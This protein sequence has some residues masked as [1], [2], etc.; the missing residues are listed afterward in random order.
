[1]HLKP[2]AL[3]TSYRENHYKANKERVA[4]KSMSDANELKLP[5]G[6]V[7]E[8]VEHENIVTS[9]KVYGG[10]NTEFDWVECTVVELGPD[11]DRSL[12][13]LAGENVWLAANVSGPEHTKFGFFDIHY[14]KFDTAIAW[15]NRDGVSQDEEISTNGSV[16][17]PATPIPIQ[18]GEPIGYIGI[19]EYPENTNS[20]IRFEY[21]CHLEVFAPKKPPSW[22]L[23]H[24]SGTTEEGEEAHGFHVIDGANSNGAYDS[25]NEFY[26]EMA[27]LVGWVP[28]AS[29]T[30]ED[31]S[32][33][34]NSGSNQLEKAVICHPT[35]WLSDS[36]SSIYITCQLEIE[37]DQMHTRCARGFRNFE[38]YRRTVFFQN[39][40]ETYNDYVAHEKIRVDD[41]VWV[42]DAVSQG[43]SALQPI[44]DSGNAWHF[45][46][47]GLMPS[48]RGVHIN[49]DEFIALYIPA[50]QQLIEG[51][52]FGPTSTAN[53][54]SI[55]NL[56]NEYY[57]ENPEEWNLHHVAYMLATAQ[58]EAYHFTSGEYFSER[59]EVG[60]REYF[61]KYDPV[62]GATKEI[63]ETAIS[64]GNTEEGD[65]YKYRGRGLVQLTWKSNYERF[66]RHFALDL[67]STPDLAG[68]HKNAVPIMIW[69]MT[70]GT[71]TGRR[72][73]HY[74][75]DDQVDYVGAR[76]VINGRDRRDKIAEYARKFERILMEVVNSA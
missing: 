62:L 38:E 11:S 61:N 46:P 2:Q 76:W 7:I 37:R 43:V 33:Y 9:S 23:H 52:R 25:G 13:R 16:N 34:F 63:R 65:G 4:F 68:Q 26:I 51:F 39:L 53:L 8:F 15:Q 35:E 69:G 10:N 12:M 64:Y 21:R 36:N 58:I 50:F 45:W 3:L 1:M 49:I 14:S 59:P 18:A 31:I 27:K 20:D 32:R 70:E 66:G 48:A 17:A 74:I 55:L 29:I 24:L 60:D 5:K 19:H 30:G 6:T 56:L 40:Q 73:S 28:R 22:F 57:A 75:N 54:R 71:I 42:K 44:V 72:L 67:V 47:L 41:S